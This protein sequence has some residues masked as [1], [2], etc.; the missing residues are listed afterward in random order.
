MPIPGTPTPAPDPVKPAD[1]D[2]RFEA[3][4]GDFV[5]IAKTQALGGIHAGLGACRQSA[6]GRVQAI[7]DDRKPAWT[8]RD[9]V[10]TAAE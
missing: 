10:R 5:L 4:T 9:G 3:G 1:I 6:A 2:I 7:A 8:E